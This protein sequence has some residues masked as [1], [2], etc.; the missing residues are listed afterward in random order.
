MIR[1]LGFLFCALAV[2]PA[3]AGPEQSLT[4]S[5][6]ASLKDVLSRLGTDF[7]KT[8]PNARLKFNFG[9]SGTLRA[10]VE[11]G[12]PV[13]VFIAADDATMN[14]LQKSG[15]IEASSRR[16]LAG[17]HLVLI[18]PFDS[19]AQ[20]LSFRDLARPDVSRV[21]IGAPSVPAGKRARE[22]FAR[23]GI[24]A[25]IEAKAVRGKDVRE[26]LAQVEAGNVEAGMVYSSDAATTRRVRV[27]AEAPDSLHAP[28]R[29]PAAIVSGSKNRALAARFLA[30]LSSKG[31]RAVFQGNHFVIPNDPKA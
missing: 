20:I 1:P 18:V 19:R 17:N 13:D 2:S 3:F 28:I 25:Q 5:A 23:L 7:Q 14:A 16:V 29:Y 15:N 27:V 22:V 31:A 10:Q 11:A 12:A 8:N 30:F 6:A 21:A 4:V 26:V 9:S 24:G